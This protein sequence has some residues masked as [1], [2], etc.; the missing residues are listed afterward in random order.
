MTA[1]RAGAAAALLA[2][3]LA[4]CGGGSNRPAATATTTTTATAKATGP[5]PTATVAPSPSPTSATTTAPPQA[6]AEV[7]AVFT[8][9]AGGAVSPPTVSVPAAVPVEVTVVSRDGRAHTAMLKGHSLKV[10]AGGRASVLISGLA[11]GIY[12]LALDGTNRG[13]LVIGGQP[14]P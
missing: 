9:A 14:G 2:L 3:T 10:P 1:P 4:A 13:A 12:P 7:P 11:P 5:S 6:H 8:V